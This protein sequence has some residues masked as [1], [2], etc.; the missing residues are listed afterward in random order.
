MISA[1]GPLPVQSGQPPIGTP[2]ASTNAVD[3][4]AEAAAI[5]SDQEVDDLLNAMWCREAPSSTSRLPMM[6]G[7]TEFFEKFSNK[8]PLTDTALNERRRLTNALLN[9]P[10]FAAFA[11]Q[12]K[13]LE[14][15][16]EL[17]PE[18]LMA[19]QVSARQKTQGVRQR[20]LFF[21]F[22]HLIS[23]T[24]KTL[25][26]GN[27]SKAL[28]MHK[29]APAKGSAAVDQAAQ[30]ERKNATSTLDKNLV[31]H[32]ALAQLKMHIHNKISSR[33]ESVS[34]DSKFLCKLFLT[35]LP[36]EITSQAGWNKVQ[37]RMEKYLQHTG[38]IQ[39]A[40]FNELLQHAIKSGTA[41]Q[42]SASLSFEGDLPEDEL[43]P[44]A[45]HRELWNITMASAPEEHNW[46][47]LGCARSHAN[48]KAKEAKEGE[49]PGCLRPGNQLSLTMQTP[50]RKENG[51]IVNITVVSCVGPALDTEKQPE[52]R[53]YVSRTKKGEGQEEQKL[54]EQ[55]YTA[56]FECI[57]KQVRNAVTANPTADQV[58]LPAISMGAFLAG[59][60]KD[61]SEQAQKIAAEVLADLAIELRNSGKTVLIAD[62]RPRMPFWDG[63][64]ARLMAKH[65]PP[66]EF[67]GP[68][69]GDWITEGMLIVNAWD[70][71]SLVGNGLNT[72]RSF[73]G[74][75]GRSSLL[76]FIHAL[77]CAAYAEDVN[78]GSLSPPRASAS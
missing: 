59:L 57:K 43:K 70:P 12:F 31:R 7:C 28:E 34:P 5:F 72:D 46:E 8:E 61:Q 42:L 16:S 36:P 71:H 47:V 44:M 29:E 76:H 2:A 77:H 75:M 50:I 13:S 23:L 51:E 3:A 64:D 25:A 62:L 63:V 6:R 27:L 41:Y 20:H 74:Y 17:T 53:A 1:P 18:R 73:D 9:R 19:I 65:Q 21:S 48:T 11:S 26:V 55:N 35:Q 32:A 10:E 15:K 30:N 22:L 45:F 52:F 4:L 69:P 24:F 40:C 78:L 58:A 56:A 39:G 14:N 66:L 54:N 37:Q 49:I 68:I 60:N 33:P 38:S 67:G